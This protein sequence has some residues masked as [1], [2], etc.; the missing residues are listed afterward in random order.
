MAACYD[1]S[2]LKE[3]RDEQ[4]F[5]A[6]TNQYEKGRLLAVIPSGHLQMKA[7]ETIKKLL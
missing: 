6:V 7:G 1:N 2:S 4:R 5:S 3:I